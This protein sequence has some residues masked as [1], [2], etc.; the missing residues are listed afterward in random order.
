MLLDGGE[1][2]GAVGVSDLPRVE[3][4]LRVQQLVPGGHDGHHGELVHAD[5]GHSHC[6]EQ[7]D[8][9]RAHVR[10]F[11]QNALPSPDVVTDRPAWTQKHQIVYAAP[12]PV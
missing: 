2:S 12:S 10:A 1:E 9:R 11:S 8:L 3:V 6:G 4:I 7:A 5:L